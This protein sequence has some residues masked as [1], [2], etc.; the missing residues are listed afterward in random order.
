MHSL[1]ISTLLN[2]DQHQLKDCFTE[3]KYYKICNCE[4]AREIDIALLMGW[5]NLANTSLKRS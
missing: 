3:A 2:T 4:I 1:R 5:I